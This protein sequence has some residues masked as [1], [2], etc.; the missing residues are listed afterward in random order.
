MDVI[1]VEGF[2]FYRKTFL[3]EVLFVVVFG[4]VVRG[5]FCRVVSKVGRDKFRMK[6][7]DEARRVL[8][9]LA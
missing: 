2:D 6:E 8:D 7:L 5:F 9:K 1:C 3:V 4:G